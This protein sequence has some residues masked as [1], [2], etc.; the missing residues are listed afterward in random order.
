MS[1]KQDVKSWSLGKEKQ[2]RKALL[3]NFIMQKEHWR[4]WK[5]ERVKWFANATDFLALENSEEN[6]VI[7]RSIWVLKNQ[8]FEIAVNVFAVL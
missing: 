4:K 2:K 7:C 3:F 1:K 5:E 8:S 6:F